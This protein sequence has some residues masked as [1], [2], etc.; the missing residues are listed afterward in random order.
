[1]G[2]SVEEMQEPPTASLRNTL[3][4]TKAL[5]LDGGL[6]AQTTSFESCFQVSAWYLAAQ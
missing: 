2:S 6:K 3:L 5:A 1:V 4:Q